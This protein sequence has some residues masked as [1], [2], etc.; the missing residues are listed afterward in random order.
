V[1]KHVDSLVIERL[2]EKVVKTALPEIVHS[3]TKSL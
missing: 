3:E 2:Q 1:R